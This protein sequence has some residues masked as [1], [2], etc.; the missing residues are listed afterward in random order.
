[1]GMSTFTLALLAQSLF[2]LGFIDA[3]IVCFSSTRCGFASVLVCVLWSTF[4]LE[5]EGYLEIRVIDISK[6][7]HKN[8]KF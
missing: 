5:A 6:S 4:W 1:M 2:P 8:P 3:I 7:P